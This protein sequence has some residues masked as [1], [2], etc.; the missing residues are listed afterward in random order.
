MR[1]LKPI[2]AALLAIGLLIWPETALNAARE[3]MATWAMSVAPALFPFMVLM[4]MLTGAECARAYEFLLGRA[5]RPVLNLPGRAAPALAAGMTAGSPAGA[6]AAARIHGLNRAERERIVCCAC[7]LS[8]A[9]LVTGIGASM[10]GSAALGRILLRSQIVSQLALLL[11]TR[12]ARPSEAL[13]PSA[14]QNS[15]PILAILNVCGSMMIFTTAAALITRLTRNETIGIAILT[16]LDLPSGARALSA[17]PLPADG[18]LLLLSAATGF[19][20]LCIAV[21]NLSA[22]PGVRASRYFAM[23]IASAALMTAATA[24]Q[25]NWNPLISE[26]TIPPIPLSALFAVILIVPAVI[27]WNKNPFL[28]KENSQKKGNL[29][30]EK[31]EKAQDVVLK[32]NENINIL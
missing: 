27:F 6:L 5:L 13:E 18:K 10:L 31:P 29:K 8:P 15:N 2:V 28:N 3:A 16:A 12:A 25:L 14:P 24:L 21:Q 30:L 4:P 20:G 23:R 7:G 32:T 11:L 1:I 17:L 26:K 19:G 9:F 22:C